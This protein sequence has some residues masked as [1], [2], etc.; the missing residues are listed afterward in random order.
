MTSRDF[1]FV[2]NAVQANIKALLIGEERRELAFQGEETGANHTS[3]S[4]HEVFNVACGDQISLNDMVVMLRKI[5]GKD[6]EA[7]YG[8]ERAGDVRHSKASIE[9]LEKFC[10]YKP[11]FRFQA[12]LEIVYSWYQGRV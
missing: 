5:S 4:K 11:K 2:E 1:T 6:I 3:R 12:G 7:F 9:K 10:G 8:P